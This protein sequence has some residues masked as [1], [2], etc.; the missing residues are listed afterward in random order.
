MLEKISNINWIEQCQ[1]SSWCEKACKLGFLEVISC[2]VTDTLGLL[3]VIIW[4]SECVNSASWM[5]VL[6]KCDFDQAKDEFM[7]NFINTLNFVIIL[8]SW[9]RAVVNVEL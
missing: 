1:G 3:I 5:S 4:G 8:S 7:T 9:I 6:W 2:L